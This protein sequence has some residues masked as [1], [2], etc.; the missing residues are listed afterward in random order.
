MHD[1]ALLRFPP[2]NNT[3]FIFREITE[4]PLSPIGAG[5]IAERSDPVTT[6][7]YLAYYKM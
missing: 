6:M 3:A 7:A 4:N 5:Y 2:R 1:A